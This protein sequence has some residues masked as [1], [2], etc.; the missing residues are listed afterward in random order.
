MVLPLTFTLFTLACGPSNILISKSIS[1]LSFADS[2]GAK[3][4]YPTKKYCT[5]NGAM[6]AYTGCKKY[7]AGQIYDLDGE[8][9]HRWPLDQLV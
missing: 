3:A 6:I 5:D 8:V 7:K 1:F 4:Y 9:K 2:I